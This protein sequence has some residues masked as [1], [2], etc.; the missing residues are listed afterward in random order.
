MKF[1]LQYLVL[2]LIMRRVHKI[3]SICKYY[4]CRAAVTMV[5]MRAEFVGPLGRHGRHLQTI[6]PRLRIV[7]CVCSVQENREAR[8]MWNAVCNSFLECKKHETA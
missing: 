8:R 4:C 2:S 7:L 3:S 6:E 5:R 1:Y